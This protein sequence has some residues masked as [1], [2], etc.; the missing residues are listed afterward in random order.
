MSIKIFKTKPENFPEKVALCGC[1][2]IDRRL[3]M[4]AYRKRTEWVYDNLR[5]GL[6]INT[7]I[8]C[9]DVVGQITAL[10]LNKS[11]IELKGDG[12]WFIPCIWMT[13]RAASPMLGEQLIDG[14][15]S[16]LGSS[17]NGVVTLSSEL[18]M[19]HKHFI[20][21]FGFEELGSIERVGDKVDIMGLSLNGAEIAVELIERKPP[22]GVPPRLDFFCSAHCPSHASASYRLQN[23][24]KN[25]ERE[26]QLVV[27]DS[28]DR[29]VIEQFGYSWALLVNGERDV[30]KNFITGEPLE[31]IVR[32]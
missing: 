27:H 1:D 2:V 29:S 17:A 9:G 30:L 21:R 20:E 23:E 10:P 8:D 24:H 14:L 3:I 25:L 6:I 7:A 13:P 26:V 15:V 4:G 19:N 22:K 5:H 16:D 12:L 31:E 11:P 18:W 28:S 32:R